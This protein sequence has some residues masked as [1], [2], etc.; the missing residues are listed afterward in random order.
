M[1]MRN[2]IL[3][4]LLALVLVACGSDDAFVGGGNGPGPGPGPGPGLPEVAHLVLA[5]SATSIPADGSQAAEIR[6]LLLDENRVAVPGVPVTFSADSGALSA[7]VVQSGDD[8]YAVV[9]L[10]NGG[11]STPRSIVVTATAE[12]WTATVTVGVGTVVSSTPVS[13][14]KLLSSSTTMPSDGSAPATIVAVVLGEGNLALAGVPVSFSADSGGLVV[15]RGVT[16]NNGE[17]VAIL[18]TAGDTSTR[19]I[20]V[21]AMAGSEDDT[22]TVDVVPAI[23]GTSVRIGNGAFTSFVPN[24]IGIAPSSISAG[25]STTLVVNLV[26]QDGSLY[27]SPVTVSFNSPCVAAQTA[28]F[29]VGDQA[30]SSV[31]TTTGQVNV[32]YVAKGCQGGDTISARASVEGQIL[33]A[34]GIVTVAPASA[35]AIAFVSAAPE[36]I[37]LKNTG[38]ASRPETSIVVFKVTDATGGPVAGQRVNFSLSTDVGGIS[39]STTSEVTDALG[40][41]QVVVNSGTVATTVRVAA[42]LDDNPLISTQSSALTISTGIPTHQRFSLSVDRFNIDAFGVDGVETTITARLGDRFGNPVPDGTPVSFQAEAGGSIDPQCFTGPTYGFEVGTCSV[43][44]RSHGDRMPDGRVSILATVIGEESFLDLD[45]DGTFSEGDHL[46]ED[47][48]EP[49]LDLDENGVYDVD[50]EPFYDFFPDQ[51]YTYGDGPLNKGFNGVLCNFECAQSPTIGLGRQTV[52]VLSA[53]GQVRLDLTSHDPSNPIPMTVDGRE[54]VTFWVRDVNGNP[55]PQGSKVSVSLDKVTEA[56]E[57]KVLGVS[58][59]DVPS[60]NAK[61]GFQVD[62][63]TSFSFEIMASKSVGTGFLTVTVE[64]PGRSPVSWTF[65]LAVN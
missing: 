37:A 48:S 46:L 43:K 63:E 12:E 45:G 5:S 65:D 23:S 38:E 44:F 9:T 17:A 42:S 59:Q 41:V 11:D 1:N 56:M 20:A 18:N 26:R 58:S 54:R 25:G 60:T 2:K 14:I 29:R 24:V 53:G 15:T 32:T 31:T 34:T 57:L 3:G 61:P 55:L 51:S 8:G 4:S 62:G 10:T 27:T 19:T 64:V 6:A 47:L 52:L 36:N 49:W 39:L 28:E 13:S 21:T 16:D 33:E 7:G 30:Q 40:N 50:Q 22:I 35:G